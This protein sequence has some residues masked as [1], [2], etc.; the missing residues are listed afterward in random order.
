MNL[1]LVVLVHLLNQNTVPIQNRLNLPEVVGEGAPH[2]AGEGLRVFVG[3]VFAGAIGIESGGAE[4]A[5][6]GGDAHRGGGGGG[7]GGG[8]GGG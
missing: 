6:G 7:G 8:S 3:F 2:L 4:A 1:R 5:V